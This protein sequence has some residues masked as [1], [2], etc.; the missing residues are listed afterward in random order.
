MKRVAIKY[1]GGCDPLYDRVEWVQRAEE[2][3]GEEIRW[4]RYD[5]G[6]VFDV[7][8]LVNG[9][10][11]ACAAMGLGGDVGGAA[12]IS[13]TKGDVTPERVVG[14]ILT[15]RGGSRSRPAKGA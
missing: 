1:C 6:E 7:V 8:L 2:V 14:W 10:E 15:C 13:V 12:C 4:V 11:R 9:C 5:A 3:G